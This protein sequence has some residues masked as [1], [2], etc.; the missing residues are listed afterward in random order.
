M[1]KEN[2]NEYEQGFAA[3]MWMRKQLY[4]KQMDYQDQTEEG[5]ELMVK[6]RKG[7]ESRKDI[8]IEDG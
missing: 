5:R 4:Q 8:L 7:I 1:V 3:F 2:K 6:I